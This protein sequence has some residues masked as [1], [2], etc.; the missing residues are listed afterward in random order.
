MAKLNLQ[1]PTARKRLAP[2]GKP[3]KIRLLPGVH[4]G[5]R[6]AQ[7]GTGSWIVIAADGKGGYWTDAFAHADDQ[8]EADGQ[9][10]LDY[11]QAANR[12]R[13]LAR[14]DANAAAD[15]PASISDALASY[16]ADLVGRGKSD[17]NAT[18]VKVHLPPALAAQP[19]AMVTAQQLRDWRD[20]LLRDGML[21]ATCNRMIKGCKAA[22][23]LVAKLDRRIAA[24]RHAWDVGLEA[25][26][27]AVTAR[28]AV[29][30]EPQVR[31]AVAAAYAE[32]HAFGLYTQTHAETGA[33]SS[34]IARLLV[35]DLQPGRL[36]MPS[37]RK[38]RGKR[39]ADRVP[40]PL[41]KGLEARLKAVAVG[42]GDDAVLLLR[43]DGEPWDPTVTDH[44][45][46]FERAARV[47]GLPAEMT[48]YSLRH[49]SI[50]RALLRGLPVKVVADW[51]DSSPDQ[52]QRHYGR[53]IR[54]HYDELVR[55]ALIDTTPAAET[56]TVVPL[57]AS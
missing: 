17:Y 30:T 40:V 26:P 43:E 52:I 34:Q 55:A 6:A 35:G 28:K 39:K 21:P 7:S 42:R 20:K 22:L 23:N 12:C 32:S 27:D 33:R 37:S 50:A 41:T 2:R 54:D 3:Y 57:R 53:Y 5:Y 24:N 31:A 44:R 10:I 25:L 1:T 14:G 49:S 45:R 18:W 19:V 11:E 29:L 51:H 9:K 36:M 13:A 16:E 15:K 38:G 4:L 8:Q 46:P 47:A 48:I 56:A